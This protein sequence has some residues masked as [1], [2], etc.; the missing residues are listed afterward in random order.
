L[1]ESIIEVRDLSVSYR[2]IKALRSVSLTVNEGECVAIVGANG[3]GKSSLLKAIMGLVEVE[4]G[5]ILFKGEKI[6]DYPT[7]KRA[8]LGISYVP[9]GARV[10]PKITVYGNLM[11]GAYRFK[12]KAFINDRLKFVFSI[13]PRLEERQ[14]QLA[15]TLSGGERQMLSLARALMGNP[16]I[17]MVDEISL[18]LMP[19]LVDE[20]FEVI[21]NLHEKGLTIFLSEQNAHKAS[22]V[23]DRIY[24]LELGRVVKETDPQGLMEDPHIKKAY[25][26]M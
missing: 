25:L 20:V 16:E 11:L 10:F 8:A 9:E 5:D 17:L 13:F 22:E 6:N 12:D 24:I 23:A 2:K 4:V 19:K 21:D 3:A 14:S 1:A 7:H 18:G 15:G 26:G